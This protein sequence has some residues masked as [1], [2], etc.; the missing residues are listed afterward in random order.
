MHNV[1]VTSEL[2]FM[3]QVLHIRGYLIMF[4]ELYRYL[5]YRGCTH[6]SYCRYR[7]AGLAVSV[8]SHATIQHKNNQSFFNW[9]LI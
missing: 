4:S 9:N 1:Y 6:H 7:H 5:S 2:L 3:D 8:P